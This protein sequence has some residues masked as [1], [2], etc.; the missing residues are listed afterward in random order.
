MGEA[1]KIVLV[2][3]GLKNFDS[4]WGSGTLVSGSRVI[5]WAG[6]WQPRVRAQ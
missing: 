4:L 6:G 5:R 1:G 3:D 2:L